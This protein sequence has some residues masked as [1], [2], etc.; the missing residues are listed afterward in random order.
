MVS[1]SCSVYEY[2]CWG[3]VTSIIIAFMHNRF[4]SGNS[5]VFRRDITTYTCYNE[6]S[7]LMGLMVNYNFFDFVFVITFYIMMGEN[8]KVLVSSMAF[9]VIFA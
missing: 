6:Y 4:S 2:V 7:I 8:F 9:H 3:Y 1:S 5:K